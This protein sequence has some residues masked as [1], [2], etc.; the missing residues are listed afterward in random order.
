MV[1]SQGRRGN[2]GVQHIPKEGLGTGASITPSTEI[3]ILE[4]EGE[5]K[6][7]HHSAEISE[8][9]QSQYAGI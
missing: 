1:Y 5:T 7:T 6:R 2:R 4:G 9:K 8:K 3:S